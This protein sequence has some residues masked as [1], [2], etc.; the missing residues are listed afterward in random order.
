[1]NYLDYWREYVQ[2]ALCGFM[3]PIAFMQAIKYAVLT[4]REL[5]KQ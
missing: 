5:R 3:L 1:M 2:I 4:V